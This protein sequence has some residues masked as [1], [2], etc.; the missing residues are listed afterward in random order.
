MSEA[1]RALDVLPGVFI[2]VI[3]ELVNNAKGRLTVKMAP[4]VMTVKAIV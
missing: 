3:L 2:E 4:D 1:V